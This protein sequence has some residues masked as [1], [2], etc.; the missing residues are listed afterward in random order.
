MH[1]EVGHSERE[2]T[3]YATK[4]LFDLK[5]V[6]LHSAGEAVNQRIDFIKNLKITA[7]FATKKKTGL[8]CNSK[9]FHTFA[10]EYKRKNLN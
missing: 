6:K 5:H 7:D 10:S 9:W 4:K 1:Y 8:I 3:E 2:K